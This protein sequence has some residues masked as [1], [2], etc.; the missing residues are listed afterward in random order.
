M[1]MVRLKEARDALMA[2]EWSPHQAAVDEVSYWS[3]PTASLSRAAVL[4]T[5]ASEERRCDGA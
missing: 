2:G 1:T 3:A 4:D 5:L